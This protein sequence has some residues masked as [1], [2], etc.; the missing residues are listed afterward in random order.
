MYLGRIVPI[1]EQFNA[2]EPSDVV[3]RLTIE[4]TDCGVDERISFSA[5]KVYSKEEDIYGKHVLQSS[6]HQHH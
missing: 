5:C 2:E 6:R 1:G 3:V 4:K